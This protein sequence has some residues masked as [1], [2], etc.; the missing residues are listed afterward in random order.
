MPDDQESE[1]ESQRRQDE[2]QVKEAEQEKRDRRDQERAG[3]SSEVSEAAIELDRESDSEPPPAS[4]GELDVPIVELDEEPAETKIDVDVSEPDV[5]AEDDR[6]LVVPSVELGRSMI[7]A[8]DV[9]VTMEEPGQEPRTVEPEVPIVKLGKAPQPA[10][11]MASFR[12]EIIDDASDESPQRVP[13]PLYQ[14]TGKPQVRFQP[15]LHA[16]ISAEIQGRIVDANQQSEQ[17][18]TDPGEEIEETAEQEQEPEV[19]PT[20]QQM[21][22]AAGATAGAGGLAGSEF[23]FVDTFL[24]GE[25]K[26]A[27]G[28]FGGEKRPVCLVLSEPEEDAFD[29][30]IELICREVYRERSEGEPQPSKR[31][32][33]DEIRDFENFGSLE[34]QIN[35]VDFSE[36]TRYNSDQI[37]WDKLV[38]R[39]RESFAQGYGFL[40]FNTPEQFAGEFLFDLLEQIGEKGG[41]QPR[42]HGI[43]LKRLSNELKK[44]IAELCWGLV[45][46]DQQRDVDFGQETDT[47]NG[48]FQAAE[49]RWREDL[50]GLETSSYTWVDPHGG[51]NES[52]RHYLMK[53]FTV[54]H[55]IEN[56]G[57][58]ESQ[59]QTESRENGGIPDIQV[60]SRYFEVETL[61]GTGLPPVKLHQTVKKYR[62][63]ADH[64]EIVLPSL[65]LLRHH[66]TIKKIQQ[67]YQDRFGI[68][69]TFYTLNLGD[70]KLVSLPE[71][72][73]ERLTELREFTQV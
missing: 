39:L 52:D 35:T 51:E 2:Q 29:H 67:R 20:E 54:K 53:M 58:D 66:T 21:E 32:E 59:I 13:V 49:Q 62:G 9:D 15:S 36:A 60:G 24:R 30:A 11:R 42:L 46:L 23:E 1:Q 10:F 40:I 72:E 73:D 19:L 61:F 16:D 3:P 12:T 43:G 22:A 70:E 63:Q 57:F 6:D 4:P 7:T 44:E 25:L 18:V 71:L 65:A 69:T 68:D 8:L 45:D 27:G 56:E 50:W 47:L 5:A 48:L 41:I 31:T 17:T 14:K 28:A 38:N 55:L 37:D 26:P 34:G 33:R 64:V